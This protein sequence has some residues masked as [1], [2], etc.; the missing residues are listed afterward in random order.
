MIVVLIFSTVSK[1]H[2]NNLIDFLKN[3][4]NLYAGYNREGLSI[5][6]LNVE[7]FKV[8]A[9][10]FFPS[11]SVLAAL[12]EYVTIYEYMCSRKQMALMK[13][14]HMENVLLEYGG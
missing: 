14:K 10:I 2:M 5:I 13:K 4:S 1:S 8:S 12:N 6:L 3:Y 7:A 11:I 9:N